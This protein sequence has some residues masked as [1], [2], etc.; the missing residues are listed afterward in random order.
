MKEQTKQEKSK[1]SSRC[2]NSRN[3]ESIIPGHLPENCQL[4]TEGGWNAREKRSPREKNAIDG[5]PGSCFT[6]LSQSLREEQI[7]DIVKNKKQGNE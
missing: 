3:R 7:I 6:A 4:G 1:G 2:S 5:L